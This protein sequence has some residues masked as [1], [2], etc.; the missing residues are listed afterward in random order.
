MHLL[1]LV[2]DLSTVS[3]EDRER[4]C[5]LTLSSASATITQFKV[6]W[7]ARCSVA[8]GDGDRWS[9]VKMGDLG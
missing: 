9:I 1:N 8:L 6:S 3:A 4:P 2:P 7:V 5:I